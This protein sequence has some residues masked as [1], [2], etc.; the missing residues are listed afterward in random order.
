MR[1]AD[2]IIR[3]FKEENVTTVFGYP[4]AAIMPLYEALRTSG[5]HHVLVRHEQA[6]G[7]SANGYARVKGEVGVC[8]VTSGPGATNIITG[9]ATAYMD[10]IPLVVITGQVR[11]DL[12][13]KDVFQ[14]VDITGAT[15]PFVKHSYLVKD[16]TQI[17]K[18]I[19]EA[20]HIAR[21]GRPGPVLIDI[22]ADVFAQQIDYTNNEVDIRGYKP[23]KEGHVGQIKRAIK[24]LEKSKRPL[25]CVGGGVKIAHAEKELIEF[26]EKTKIPAVHTLMGLGVVPTK[27]PYNLGMIGSHGFPLG[28]DTLNKADTVVFIGA[29]VSDRSIIPA[30]TFSEEVEI[31][32]I[33]VDPAEIGKNTHANIP[34]VGDA[35]NILKQMVELAN[36]LDTKDWVDGMKDKHPTIPEE[37]IYENA[38]NPKLMIQELSKLLPDD[39]IVVG[40]VGQNQMWAGRHIEI[41][42]T[43]QF[44]TSGGLGTMGYALPA[45]IG[46]CMADKE[47]TVV[48]VMGDGGLQ[49]CFGELATMMQEGL[50]PI[51]ILFNNTKLGMVHEMQ[52][53]NYNK[54][55]GV[56]LNC[57]P[58]FA[59]ISRAY[60]IETARISNPDEM[61]A[62]LK[63]AVNYD[64]PFLI[65]CIV[66]PRECTL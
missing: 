46:V 17:S 16:G 45:S 2:A 1:V 6:A 55:Y 25:I 4:G 36:E 63:Q 13:G 56:D 7:H 57:N 27:H 3:G 24:S 42:G 37:H 35:K 31:I 65:E 20:F 12:I 30:N 43:R 26:I 62:I 9:I 51:I 39:A 48:S 11:S 28:N 60:G 15:E 21:T 18:I 50:K 53:K 49:M 64:G 40:D 19:K 23:T 10:S 5:I 54:E 22:P 33:D 29:R 32:H 34:L 38:I 44:L 61:L 66:D 47:R 58:D 14:E 8:V 41:K 52:Y 59:M